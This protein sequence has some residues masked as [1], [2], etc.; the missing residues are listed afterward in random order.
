[1]ILLM[2]FVICNVLG[3]FFFFYSFSD[4]YVVKYCEKCVPLN[5]KLLSTFQLNK[6]SYKIKSPDQRPLG[7]VWDQ[8]S[9]YWQ[10]FA[11]ELHV[12]ALNY[13]HMGPFPLDGNWPLVM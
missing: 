11:L 13:V 1:M 3:H 8:R 7:I 2:G 5:S 4:F 10:F 9:Q 6:T 12:W